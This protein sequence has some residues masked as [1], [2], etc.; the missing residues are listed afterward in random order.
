MEDTKTYTDV[1]IPELGEVLE[2]LEYQP[3]NITENGILARVGHNFVN[4]N[5]TLSGFMKVRLRG[6]AKNWL[7]AQP[8]G[9]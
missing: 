5:R 3:K 8:V 2:W 7:K 4:L 1:I 6:K 9:E